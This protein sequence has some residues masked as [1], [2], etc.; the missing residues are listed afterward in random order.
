M[1][2]DGF[3]SRKIEEIENQKKQTAEKRKE[4]KQQPNKNDQPSTDPKTPKP[5]A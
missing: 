4:K 5:T 3:S 2:S 1:P